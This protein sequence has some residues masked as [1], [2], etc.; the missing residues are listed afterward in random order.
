[1]PAVDVTCDMAGEL[2]AA[3]LDVRDVVPRSGEIG[4]RLEVENLGEFVGGTGD[5]DLDG[6]KAIGPDSIG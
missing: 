3:G 5:S 6:G 1:M 2:A 4:P